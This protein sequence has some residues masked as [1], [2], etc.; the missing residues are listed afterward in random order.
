MGNLGPQPRSVW[1]CSLI[2]YI[3]L[4]FSPYDVLHTPSVRYPQVEGWTRMNILPSFLLCSLLE[5]ILLYLFIAFLFLRLSEK[6]WCMCEN[7]V[8]HL[9]WLT[10]VTYMITLLA[11]LQ[12]R[13]TVKVLV[14][15]KH[16]RDVHCFIQ[17]LSVSGSCYVSWKSIMLLYYKYFTLKGFIM[18]SF[19]DI[20]CITHQYKVLF[21]TSR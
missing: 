5:S 4:S 19:E 16:Y 20:S 10:F 6:L 11:L 9:C 12:S 8:R 21:H 18:C 7:L 14:A 17:S 13:W 2:K 15:Y 1:E 3:I